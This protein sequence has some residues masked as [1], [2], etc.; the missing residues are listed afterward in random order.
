M[1][2]SKYWKIKSQGVYA[3]RGTRFDTQHIPGVFAVANA[4]DG[5]SLLF[6]EADT[7]LWHRTL[8]A[9]LAHVSDG[10][11]ESLRG[12]THGRFSKLV[13]L[14]RNVGL[15]VCGCKNL[16]HLVDALSTL[17]WRLKVMK[18]SR[19]R[20]QTSLPLV[21]HPPLCQV[22]LIKFTRFVKCVCIINC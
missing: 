11:E 20:P 8:S 9:V 6:G 19:L 21:H 3:P 7:D 14:I 2:R 15:H 22:H 5:V 17:C 16:K 18:T 12:Q 13:L 1:V 10:W 4:S